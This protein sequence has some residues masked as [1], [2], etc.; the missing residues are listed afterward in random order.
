MHQARKH[1]PGSEH[2]EGATPPRPSVGQKASDPKTFQSGRS[3]RNALGPPL[4]HGQN[5]FSQH[6]TAK[7]WHGH[8]HAQLCVHACARHRVRGAR[9]WAPSAVAAPRRRRRAARLR[10]PRKSPPAGR[11]PRPGC[12]TAPLSAHAPRRRPARGQRAGAVRAAAPA[13]PSSSGGERRAR[14][15]AGARAT[16]PGR[17]THTYGPYT[18]GR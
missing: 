2:S 14:R 15:P 4:L 16:A 11:A 9:V 18:N 3:G 10:S 6:G 7:Y 1:A 12:R 13:G 17:G 8:T 5:A